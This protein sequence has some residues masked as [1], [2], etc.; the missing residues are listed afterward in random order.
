MRRVSDDRIE[1]LVSWRSLAD[2]TSGTQRYLV[3][4]EYA[5]LEWSVQD[6]VEH[7]DCSGRREGNLLIVR[8]T[9]KGEAVDESIGIDDK[10]FYFNPS[11]SLQGFVRSGEEKCEFRTLRPASLSEYKMKAKVE[12]HTTITIQGREYP[13]VRVKWGL[14]GFKSRFFNQKLWFRGHAAVSPA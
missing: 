4:N 1:V 6:T 10:P 11:L 13:A 9:L 14:T 3:D 7:T 5:T 2:S 8:G 12:E